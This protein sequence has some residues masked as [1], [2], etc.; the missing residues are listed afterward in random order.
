MMPT[1]G[2]YG[3]VEGSIFGILTLAQEKKIK[4]ELKQKGNFVTHQ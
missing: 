2:R 4:K 3:S 1:Q